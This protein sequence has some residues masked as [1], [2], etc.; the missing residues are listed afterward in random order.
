MLHF[1]F[2]LLLSLRRPRLRTP[3]AST[4]SSGGKKIHVSPTRPHHLPPLKTVHTTQRA[5]GSMNICRMEPHVLRPCYC[6]CRAPVNPHKQPDKHRVTGDAHM[7]PEVSPLSF[8]CYFGPSTSC[9]PA[10]G[11]YTLSLDNASLLP[12]AH[13]VFFIANAVRLT[14]T[15]NFIFTFLSQIPS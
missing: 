1:N 9:S 10:P 15:Y 6:H 12:L 2:P 5:I 4:E 14:F 3:Q 7:L 13:Q 11:H 8:R